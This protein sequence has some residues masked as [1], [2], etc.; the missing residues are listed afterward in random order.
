MG[1]KNLGAFLLALASLAVSCGVQA[2]AINR[3]AYDPN[4]GFGVALGG[5]QCETDPPVSPSASGCTIDNLLDLGNVKF[6]ERFEGQTLSRSGNSD[7][8]GGHDS[9]QSPQWLLTG[10]AGKNLALVDGGVDGILLAGVGPDGSNGG[11]PKT[12]A[13]GT[14]ALSLFFNND[15]S[16]FDFILHGWDGFDADNNQSTLFLAFFNFE[17]V[18]IGDV[19]A[20][21]DLVDGKNELGFSREGGRKDIAGVSIWSNDD[22]GFQISGMRH[23]VDGDRE[24]GGTVPAPSAL[25]LSGLAL[26]AASRAT[27]RKNV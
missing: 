26:L 13:L 17:G 11:T 9:V 22:F 8:L 14:G 10:D 16:R 1:P 20:L 15:Q 6:G 12:A 4:G 5:L 18:L 19:L 23:D 7:M 3:V 25:L 24:P 21:S 2:A 27:R